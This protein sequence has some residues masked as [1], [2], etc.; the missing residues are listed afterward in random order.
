MAVEND[1]KTNHHVLVFD[2]DDDG[3]G[4]ISLEFYMIVDSSS[5]ANQALENAYPTINF[6]EQEVCRSDSLSARH[7]Q[8]SSTSATLRTRGAARARRD[9][10]LR[11]QEDHDWPWDIPGHTAPAT[12]EW[13]IGFTNFADLQGNRRGYEYQ[14]LTT[15][16][17]G[18]C[19]AV[20]EAL[21][22]DYDQQVNN[23]GCIPDGWGGTDIKFAIS[24]PEDQRCVREVETI[25]LLQKCFPDMPFQKSRLGLSDD[26]CDAPASWPSPNSKLARRELDPWGSVWN[27]ASRPPTTGED[28]LHMFAAKTSMAGVMGYELEV[29]VPFEQRNGCDRLYSILAQAGTVGEYTCIDDTRGGT[30]AKFTMS[31]ANGDLC[32]PQVYEKINEAYPNFNVLSK[33][34]GWTGN[35]VIPSYWPE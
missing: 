13:P 7:D 25:E 11:K 2:C 22:N 35:C 12:Q 5:E 33:R 29:N 19:L 3:S 10:S 28:P 17:D 9:I 20:F 16:D 1:L 27:P 21:W 8:V 6:V 26:K 31:I 24:M 15:F 14:L 4:Q 30:A 34:P 18:K 32:Q 23:F